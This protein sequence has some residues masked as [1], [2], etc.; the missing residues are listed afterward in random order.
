MVIKRPSEEQLNMED[1]LDV[2]MH[3]TY[4]HFTLN[5][6][7]SDRT[8]EQMRKRLAKLIADYRNQYL[9]IVVEN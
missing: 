3:D 9:P 8:D 6:S 1:L 4:I 7:R 2:I 5:G